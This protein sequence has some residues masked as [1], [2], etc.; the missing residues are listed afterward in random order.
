MGLTV[1]TVLPSVRGFRDGPAATPQP[2]VTGSTGQDADLRGCA[3]ILGGPLQAV[4]VGDPDPVDRGDTGRVTGHLEDDLV[5][6]R[7]RRALGRAEAPAEGL[8]RR[9][10][11]HRAAV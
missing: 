5:P 8:R 7:Q 6:G 3:G 1:V 4:A 9:R 11:A 2:A 10:H